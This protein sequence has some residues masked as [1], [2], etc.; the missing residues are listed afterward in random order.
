[1]W[2]AHLFT[3]S[4]ADGHLDRFKF[5]TVVNKAA[6]NMPIQVFVWPHFFVYFAYIPSNA[7]AEL[8]NCMFNFL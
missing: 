2:T 7:M 8:H 5:L 1:M 4:S 3:H 6:M